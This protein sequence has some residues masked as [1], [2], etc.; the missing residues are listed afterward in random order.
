MAADSEKA[1]PTH[2]EYEGAPTAKPGFRPKFKRHCARF[3]W[4]YTIVFIIV[5]LVVVLPVVYVAYPHA[6]QSAI[7]KSALEV[8]SMSLLN[9]APNSLDLELDSLFLSNSSLQAKL[10]AFEAD[11][12][13]ED[14]TT[15]FVQISV[16]AIK[17][18]NGSQIHISQ[19][20]QIEHNN[21]FFKY[22]ETTLLSEEYSIYLKGKGGLKYGKL[23]KTTV[24]Y[25]KKIMMKGLNG[26]KGFNV[27]EF[28]LITTAQPDGS[29][30]H[31]TVVI[32]NP[33]VTTYSLG[34]LTMS[35]FVGGFSIGNSTLQDV[36]LP[37]GNNTVPLRAVT[38]QTAV[39]ELLFT[40]Y[41]SGIFPI[42]VMVNRV[43]F[44]DKDLPYYEHALQLH[45]MTIQLDVIQVLEQA[46][47][48][49][50]LGIGNS[51]NSTSTGKA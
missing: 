2:A 8:T 24:D 47:L 12:C 50:Y 40:D 38:N 13:L 17:A 19:G 35:M 43:V 7:D 46:G 34:N 11:L 48:A 23:P 20:V 44:H 29:N 51:T 5:V 6:A 49:G 1:N 42:D 25:N 31:G 16:P 41:K 27:T 39:V 21:E 14:S 33:T 28:A 30:A 10:D 15:P 32:P 18:A 45:N 37:P 4:I 22:A 36:V 26:L 3:W 9:P